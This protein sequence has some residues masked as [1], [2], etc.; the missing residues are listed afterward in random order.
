ME[1]KATISKG[2]RW[3]LGL[4]G[5]A[6]ALFGLYFF[7]DGAIGYPKKQAKQIK[8]Q[9]T[10]QQLAESGGP[11]WQKKWVQ[12]A[13]DNGWPVDKPGE[14]MSE[15]DINAQFFYGTPCFLVG[16]W[17][18]IAYVRAGG[19]YV[20]ANDTGLET[21]GGVVVPWDAVTGVDDSRWKAKGIA[22]VQYNKDGQAG[23][24]LLDDWKFDREP[25]EQIFKRVQKHLGK[26]EPE[27][28]DDQPAEQGNQP[29]SEAP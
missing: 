5:L 18:C 2:Y 27:G 10:Y 25:T 20:L 21:N 7:Y 24:I 14:P 23:R 9:N 11:Q 12:T 1:H 19:R 29:A 4:I 3:R 6:L 28:P 13:N 8:M 22:Y 15:W 26:D 17:F 16:V